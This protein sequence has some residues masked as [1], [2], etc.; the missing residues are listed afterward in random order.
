MTL[1]GVRV[2]TG[3]DGFPT[4]KAAGV[5]SAEGCVKSASVRGES[6]APLA[7]F[8]PNFEDTICRSFPQRNSRVQIE[9]FP[10]LVFAESVITPSVVR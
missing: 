4:G 6:V 1:S 10:E 8:L 5:F 3:N 2:A 9:C 7:C